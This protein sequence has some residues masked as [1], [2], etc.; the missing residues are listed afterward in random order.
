MLVMSLANGWCYVAPKMAWRHKTSHLRDTSL[1]SLDQKHRVAFRFNP[2][3]LW[4]LAFLWLHFDLGHGATA[5]P[6]KAKS[7]HD[8]HQASG[9]ID[10]N[11]DIRPILSDNCFRCHGPDENERKAKLRL[12]VREDAIKPSKSGDRAIFPGAPEKSEFFLRITHQDPDEI[13]PPPKS[14][15]KLTT[16]QVDLL[17]RWIEQG[18]PYATHWSYAKPM[19]PQL[20]RVNNMRWPLN[21][22]DHFIL[23]R[24]EAVRLK[25]SPEAD[26]HEL[27]RRVSLDV[28]G[29]PPTIEE[30]DQFVQDRS[31]DAYEKLVDRLLQKEAFGEHWARM[32][33]DLARYADSSGYADD[34]LRSIWA[35][36]DYVI[37]ALNADK[38]FDQFTI[39]QLAGD[40]L[41][42][43][44]EE[45]IVATAFHRNTMTNNEGGTND[46]EFRNAAIVDRVN[47]TMSV[48]MGTSFACAQ[49]HNHKYDPIS[50]EEYFQ[51]MAFLNNTEDAD[52][53][54]ESPVHKFFTRP[55]EEQRRELQSEMAPFEQKLTTATPEL[56][57]SFL[58]W[59]QS[60]PRDLNWQRLTPAK[61]PDL[62][63]NGASPTTDGAIRISSQPKAESLTAEFP[64]KVRS[65]TGLRIHAAIDPLAA[66]Q[67]NDEGKEPALVVS[68]ISAT[69]NPPSGAAISGR[70]LRVELPGKDKIL[71]LAEVQVFDGTENLAARGAASQSSTDFE[72]E[73]RRAI[74]GN[75]D[76]HFFQAKSTTHT[77]SS[78]NPWWELDLKSTQSIRR[79]VLWNRTDGQLQNRLSNFRIAI[80]NEQRDP[81]WEQQIK[82]SPSPNSEFSVDG[83][84]SIRFTAVHADKIRDGFDAAA[85][86]AEKADRKKGW[87][88]DFR[89]GN[90]P[91]L[92]LL[93]EKPLEVPAGSTLRVRLEPSWTQVET[94]EVKLWMAATEEMRLPGFA[95]LPSDIFKA[96]QQQSR[97]E[98]ENAR[99]T[100]FYFR[101]LAPELKAEREQLAAL[102]KK[103]D[104]IKP[105]TVPVMRELAGDKRRKTHVQLRGNFMDQSKE[106]QEGLPV[107]F[108]ALAEGVPKNRLALAQWL[109]DE[110]NPLTARVIANRFWEQIFGVGLVRTSEEFGAQGELPSHPDLLDWL[111]TELI[112]QKW[113][114]KQFVRLIVTSAA[115]RQSSQVSPAL[116]ERD[117]ENRLLARGPRFRLSAETIR[118]QALFVS[119]LLSRKMY[120]PSVKPP[121]PASGLTAAFGSSVDWKTSEGEDRFRRGL[122][123]EWRRTSPYPSMVTFDAPNREVCTIRRNRTNTPLQALVTLNDP[124]YVEAA[125]ALARRMWR[126]AARMEDKI[127]FG[128]RLC[129]ARSPEPAELK[130]LLALYEEARC[131][132]AQDLDQAK[133]LAT[134]PIGEWVGGANVTE[135]AALTAVANV[136]L[137]LDETLMKR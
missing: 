60:F 23:A 28:T 11:R 69:L 48:W 31:K 111:A 104:E 137:N 96:L 121:R 105:F 4:A 12:D 95:A 38:P 84:R 34:P 106:V 128:F 62:K 97:A 87:A 20:P 61:M 9:K 44:T 102:K 71:S 8:S 113:S 124:V 52:R 93:L 56:T 39:E 110:N 129:V 24:L 40:L 7:G 1:P 37:K 26:R 10:F 114:V 99:L 74:D 127:R 122:Y 123:T 83:T 53:A 14:G 101:N 133:K 72:G 59:E 41:A 49:C 54:D 81:V 2:I 131:D 89:G 19:R 42:N 15:K 43:P 112:A 21:A 119:G 90:Q 91:S 75:T 136:L 94:A 125:Q 73:A 45:Q 116:A 80:L 22:I 50:Q 100:D 17:R 65:L 118:D 3:A 47:T 92:L 117:P 120:G 25:P 79:V 30:V 103:F 6:P 16:L 88:P 27:I 55:Q 108:H 51:F 32:W 76:G 115:Y 68:R 135:L 107:A 5:A 13:M 46:E 132:F 18:A 77:K 58:K 82:E 78:E 109:I 29:L 67:S 70:Y 36:R 86:L 57:A 130:R 35:Y 134:E 63:E 85:V 66:G 33:L 64:L 98:A 126:S